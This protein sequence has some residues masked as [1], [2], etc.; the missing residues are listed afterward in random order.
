MKKIFILIIISLLVVNFAFASK[1]SNPIP[2]KMTIEE[3]KNKIASANQ[4]QFLSI[5][6]VALGGGWRACQSDVTGTFYPVDCNPCRYNEVASSC[7]EY[8]VCSGG[9]C[10][11]SS[12]SPPG[13]RFFCKQCFCSVP[14]IQC[15]GG[16]EPGDRKCEGSFVYT[17]NDRGVWELLDYCDYGC[18]GGECLER[19][20]QPHSYKQ[21]QGNNVYWYDSCG[22]IENLYES[23]ESNE[24]CS[25]SEC[26]KVCEEEYIGETIC[27]GNAVAQ[28]FQKSD[29]STEWTI[30][31]TCDYDCKDGACVEK[32]CGERPDWAKPSEWGSCLEG[33]IERV[34]YKCDSSTNFDWISYTESKPCKCSNDDMCKD[35]EKCENSVC[36]AV[37]CEENQIAQHHSCIDKKGNFGILIGVILFP[38]LVLVIIGFLIFKLFKTKIL[39]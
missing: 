23:C 7:F 39:K 37:N 19:Q 20:C 14:S 30:L 3:F 9:G 35:D 33:K 21:C 11:C 18:S 27:K 34:N 12:R 28:Q 10:S 31:E 26:V 29:C 38:L 32:E 17:C 2:K 36:K 24:K 5:L 1:L 22:N 25:N 16:G 15:S 8:G 13:T 4:E 6:S